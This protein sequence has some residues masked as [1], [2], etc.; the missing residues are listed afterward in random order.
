MTTLYRSSG[1]EYK[2]ALT[3]SVDSQGRGKAV[4]QGICVRC[5]GAGGSSKWD[6][7]GHTCWA[8]GG[9][10]KGSTYTETIYTAEALEKL[11][12]RR[13]KLEEKRA[14]ARAVIEAARQEAAAAA[15]K[16]FA[17]NHQQL[18]DDLA[19][20]QD[21][22]FLGD[23]YRKLGD[24]GS[25]TEPQVAAAQRAIDQKKADAAAQFV[26]NVGDTIEVE[27]TTVLV[28]DISIN[29]YPRIV[30]FIVLLEDAAGNVYKYIG[31][32]NAVRYT[33]GGTSKIKCSI[34]GHDE[35]KG[36]KQ[37]VIQRPREI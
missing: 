37:T 4:F 17:D 6:H 29:G 10:G 20:N 8:C 18:I 16:V 14:A 21:D 23:L 27:L 15:A 9:S 3:K 30:R 26:G 5:G 11:N 31:N 12:A 36:R 28:R 34:K 7:T 19:A 1:D 2:G 13:A 33:T 24:H 32:S 22:P 25:L 35:Y